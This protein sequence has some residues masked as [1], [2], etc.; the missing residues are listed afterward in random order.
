MCPTTKE[1]HIFSFRSFLQMEHSQGTKGSY[2]S[3][4]I[5]PLQSLLNYD[6]LTQGHMTVYGND[7]WPAQGAIDWSIVAF[8]DY[9]LVC[10]SKPYQE[11]DL[12]VVPNHHLIWYV[13]N[14]SQILRY[15]KNSVNPYA[16]FTQFCQESHI[17]FAKESLTYMFLAFYGPLPLIKIVF[18]RNCPKY[19][20]EKTLRQIISFNF[21]TVLLHRISVTR[22]SLY[23]R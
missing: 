9:G 16:S 19:Q 3:T 10:S 6:C 20:M 5:I 22:K 7:C 11:L 12:S 1:K 2:I 13:R 14:Q 18:L 15:R 8:G 4:I 23:T 21:S 17:W